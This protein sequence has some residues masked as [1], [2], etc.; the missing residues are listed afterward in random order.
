MVYVLFLLVS[1]LL[2]SKSKIDKTI[3]TLLGLDQ[4]FT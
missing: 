3:V 1:L 4:S 2:L